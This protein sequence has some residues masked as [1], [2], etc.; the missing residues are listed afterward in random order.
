MDGYGPIYIKSIAKC[1]LFSARINAERLIFLDN[2][3]EL[4]EIITAVDTKTFEKI[5][6]IFREIETRPLQ[7]YPLFR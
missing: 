3:I 4:F 2:L 1:H 5:G 6:K 7:A